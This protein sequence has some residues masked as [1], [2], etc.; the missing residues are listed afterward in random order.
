M[1]S[2]AMT[3]VLN[4]VRAHCRNCSFAGDAITV[5][6]ARVVFSFW[7]SELQELEFGSGV[8]WV[9][10]QWDQSPEP[11]VVLGFEP[12]EQIRSGPDG[13]L[14]D[15]K[16][17]LYL[18]LPVTAKQLQR[19]ID[20]IRCQKPSSLDIESRKQNAVRFVQSLRDWKHTFSNLRSAVLGGQAMLSMSQRSESRQQEYSVISG[21]GA[22]IVKRSRDNLRMIFDRSG[23]LSDGVVRMNR[24]QTDRLLGDSDETWREIKL[25]SKDSYSEARSEQMRK[26]IAELKSEFDAVEQEVK[27]ISAHVLS[28]YIRD[29]G[30]AR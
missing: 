1:N 8:A 24:T 4:A 26:K 29:A 17:I 5:G 3:N 2:V 19:S 12:E 21:M 20:T 18:E 28:V 30:A 10:R 9:S 13:A 7:N 27:N 14:F 23:M 16:G 22:D 25:L 15:L 11:T 6:D